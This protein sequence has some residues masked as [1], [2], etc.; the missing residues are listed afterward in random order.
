[1]GLD[2]K[3]IYFLREEHQYFHQV[4]LEISVTEVSY[5]DFMVWTPSEVIVIRIEPNI[6]FMETLTEKCDKFWDSFILRELVTRELEINN[7]TK[8]ISTSKVEISNVERLYCICKAKYTDDDGDMVGCDSCDNWFHL[9]CL[10]LKKIPK[11][12]VWYSR[13][14]KAKKKM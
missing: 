7:I 12:N 5:C 13:D 6:S 4:Q 14:C 9:Q 10:N 1:M 11:I 3:G 8:H 2:D